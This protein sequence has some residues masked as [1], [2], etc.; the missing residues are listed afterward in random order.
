MY[1]ML[2]VL[3]DDC[4]VVFGAVVGGFVI[5]AIYRG[6]DAYGV[7]R[8]RALGVL[9]HHDGRLD[10]VKKRHCTFPKQPVVK[11]S[12]WRGEKRIDR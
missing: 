8:R 6:G 9:G 10:F 2:G 5:F 1:A 7:I 12:R 11:A 4:C 3:G